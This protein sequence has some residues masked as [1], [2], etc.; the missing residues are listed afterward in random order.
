MKFFILGLL[1]LGSAKSLAAVEFTVQ[2]D[3]FVIHGTSLSCMAY[4][5]G[6]TTPDIQSPYVDIPQIRIANI[7]PSPFLPIMLTLKFTSSAGSNECIYFD[8]KLDAIGIPSKMSAN[9][10]LDLGCPMKCGGLKIGSKEAVTATLELLGYLEDAQ[11]MLNPVKIDKHLQI[12]N[13]R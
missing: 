6:T 10:I 2:K 7:T 13:P 3:A 11:G 9:E 12:I 1:I 8:H 4:R 5:D